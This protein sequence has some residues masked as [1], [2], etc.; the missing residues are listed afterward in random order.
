MLTKVE[1]GLPGS[2]YLIHMLRERMSRKSAQS[3]ISVIASEI[4]YA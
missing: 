3:M 4:I 2:Q 1:I